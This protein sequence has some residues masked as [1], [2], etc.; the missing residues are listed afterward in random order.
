VWTIGKF[1]GRCHK[2][3]VS[4]G[5]SGPHRSQRPES[6]IYWGCSITTSRYT[7]TSR[8]TTT[9]SRYTITSRYTTTTSRYTTTTSRYTITSR[10]TT[11]TSSSSNSS[12]DSCRSVLQFLSKITS[13]ESVACTINRDGKKLMK[14]NENQ[15]RLQI[16]RIE[17]VFSTSGLKQTSSSKSSFLCSQILILLNTT[18]I[19]CFQKIRSF[20][21]YLLCCFIRDPYRAPPMR[22]RERVILKLYFS[23]VEAV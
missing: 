19:E 18:P 22:L 12:A 1:R 9:T 21:H 15:M 8:Y 20:A 4:L 2:A 14:R 13:I 6:P 5:Q 23:F 17:D 7:I 10:Y 3:P 11:T 16:Y